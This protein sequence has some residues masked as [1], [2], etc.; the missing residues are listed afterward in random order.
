[1]EQTNNYYPPPCELSE[2]VNKTIK[3]CDPLDGKVD[4]VVARTDLCILEFNISTL[5]GTPYYCPA[6]SA[7]TGF[8]PTSATPEQNGTISAQGVKVAQLIL[9]GLKDSQGRQVYFSYQPSAT[10]TDAQ[11]QYNFTSKQWELDQSGL[12]AEWVERFLLLQNASLLPTLEG[13]TYDTLKAWIIES[14]H[15]YVG[16]LET[17]WPDLTPFHQAGGKIIHYHGESDFSIPTDSSVRYHES[18][19]QIMYPGLSYNESNAKLNA[20]YKLFLVPGAGHCDINALQPNGPFP[21]TNLQV[22]IDWVEKGVEPQTL[23]A[24]ILQGKHIGENAQICQWPLRP[25]WDAS[26]KMN[27]VYDQASIDTWHYDLDGI[28]LPVY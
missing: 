21:Q 25:L 12:G 3:I 27:C 26:G 13:I 7:T 14:L 19:R 2:I 20:W 9:N 28:P 16:T 22:M 15:T 23:N 18:V 24:T 8:V 4:G 6:V 17:T 10:F 5:I 1:M 11:T